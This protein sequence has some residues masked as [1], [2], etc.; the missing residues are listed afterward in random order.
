M[1]WQPGG[2]P[3]YPPYGQA[4][5]EPGFYPGGAAP[6]YP[7]P[8]GYP[9]PGYPQ[10][11]GYPPPGGYPQPGFPPAGGYPAPGYPPAGGN[12]PNMSGY[13]DIETGGGGAGFDFSEKTIRLAFIRKVY[14]ILMIQIGVSATFIGLFTLHQPTKLYVLQHPGMFWIAFIAMF[15]TLICITC[16]ESVRRS[17]PM[18]VIFLGIFTLAES[19]L[20]GVISSRYNA[21]YVFYAA[22][23]TCVICLAL[24][25]FAF[26]TKIDFTMMGGVLFVCVI[27]L[28]IFGIVMIFFHGKVMTLIYASLGAILFSVYLIYDTQLMIGGN[29]RY[30]ISPEEYIF[31][32]L[33]LYLDVI[34]IFLSILQI[35]GAANS[36]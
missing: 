12:N 24:T 26:Q 31:A 11:G 16:C 7:P 25:I 10:Q 34:N 13:G 2:Q 9:Q 4:P 30:S 28:M 8:G 18:N 21:E 27:V 29:H 35:L 32:S 5:P 17:S 33:N 19:F 36:D 15:V 20:L 23:I 22:V 1:S 14:S 6:G 3:G